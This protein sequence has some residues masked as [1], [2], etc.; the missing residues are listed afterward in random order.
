[1]Q[2][3]AVPRI[4]ERLFRRLLPALQSGEEPATLHARRLTTAL[5]ACIPVYL[6]RQVYKRTEQSQDVMA[7]TFAVPRGC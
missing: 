2:A 5:Q 1:M 6:A 3:E 7:N 4:V